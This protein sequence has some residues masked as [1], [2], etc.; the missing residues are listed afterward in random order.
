MKTHSIR[1]LHYGVNYHLFQSTNSPVPLN[2]ALI[3]AG[4]SIVGVTIWMSA[5]LRLNLTGSVHAQMITESRKPSIKK[6]RAVDIFGSK[7]N[8]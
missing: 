2:I 7:F 3:K 1:I 6:V 5:N 8:N 4:P